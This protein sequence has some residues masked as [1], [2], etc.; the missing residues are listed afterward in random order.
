MES[1]EVRKQEPVLFG[2]Q[3][4]GEAIPW[5]TAVLL[6]QCFMEAATLYSFDYSAS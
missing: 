3:G 1:D 4:K 2:V 6:P 5:W